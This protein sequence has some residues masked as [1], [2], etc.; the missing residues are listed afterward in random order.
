M[1]SGVA[2][3]ALAGVL[4]AA[5]ARADSKEQERRLTAFASAGSVGVEVLEG[6]GDLF[7]AGGGAAIAYGL[8]DWLD[9]GLEASYLGARELR[10]AQGVDINAGDGIDL[11]GNLHSATAVLVGRVL[12]SRPPFIRLN[13]LLELRVG[14]SWLSLTGLSAASEAGLVDDN[15]LSEHSLR[16]VVGARAGIAFR[17]T[18]ALQVGLVGGVDTGPG[19]STIGLGLELSWQYY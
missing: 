1:H 5:P 6:R 2:I 15:V 17:W 8:R 16:P 12:L 9:V 11:Y 13:P 19:H 10:L 14:V 7:A 18:D 3:A 4:V